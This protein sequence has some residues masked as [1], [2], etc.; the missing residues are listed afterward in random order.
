MKI[1]EL[2]ISGHLKDYYQK[3]GISDLYPP[4]AECI[5]KGM[6]KRKNLLVAIP[7]ASGKTLVAEMAM[8]HHVGESGKCLYIVPLKA[9]ASEKFEEFSRKDVR[10]GI[11]TGD[12]DRRDESLGKND[13]IVATSEKVDSLIR[14]SAPWLKDISLLVVDEVHL[15]DSP[16]RGA[17]LE[18]VI[19][20]MRYRNPEMQI[21]ALSATIGNPGV[22]ARWMDAELVTSEWRPVDL[23][24]GVFYNGR[25]KFHESFRTVE[26]VSKFDDLNLCMDTISEG[27]QCL[28]FVSS[29]K[30]AEAFA[31]RAASAFQLENSALKELSDRLTKLAETD[32]D[33]LLA[34]CVESGAAFHHAGLKRE[35]RTV[36]EE[37]FRKGHIRCISSTPTLAAGLNM[38]ARRVIIRDYRRFT[39]G[40]GMVPIPVREYHQMAGRAGRPHLDPYG[41]AVLIAKDDQDVEALFDWYIDAPAEDVY[42]QCGTEST[43]CTHI[44]SLIA[45]GFVRSREEISTFMDRTFFLYQHKQSRVI[46]RVIGKVLAFL[47]ETEMIAENGG[48]VSATQYG[49]L[50]SRLF[51]NP[52]GAQTIVHGISSA[53]EYSDVAL[54][55]LICSTPDMY[56]LYVSNKDIPYLER[57]LVDLDEDLWLTVPEDGEEGFFRGLKTTML[58]RDW[59]NELSDTVICERYSVGPGD[60]YSMVESVNWLLHAT[61]RLTPMFAPSFYQQVRELEYC[62]KYG[63]KRELLPLVKIRNIGRVRA[64][65]L[66]NSGIS[67]PENLQAAGFD[68]VSQILGRGVADQLFSAVKRQSDKNSGDVKE[69]GARAT[70]RK[71]QST[72]SY[73]VD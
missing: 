64:R 28:V 31:K 23:R 12:F 54:L 4:Q 60:I 7:T 2:P 29:R 1:K 66:F 71:K 57:F 35:A 59:A 51:I 53:E 30:N 70:A 19:T 21:I 6:F 37:G 52:N 39:S 10:V 63:V 24:P 50:V 45:S 62:M 13:I 56:N 11:S 65:R 61:S 18:M 3:A 72:L 5:R 40:E 17:T 32:N 67:S 36:V 48:I 9:L 68:R 49:S 73:F 38:P 20:K 34:A 16:D 25:I 41:E 55:Q 15:I 26:C 69:S 14:N 22:L 8:H 33:K 44:L 27:G 42:S 46:P 47:L 58:L 43:L